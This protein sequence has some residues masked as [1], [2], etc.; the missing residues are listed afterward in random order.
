M[1]EA[2]YILYSIKYKNLLNIYSFIKN[3]KII[4]LKIKNKEIIF[5]DYKFIFYLYKYSINIL[6]KKKFFFN[7]IFNINNRNFNILKDFLLLENYSSFYYTFNNFYDKMIILLAYLYRKNKY[8]NN[9]FI[10]E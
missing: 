9:I 5:N 10:Q 1:L 4:Y 7:N 3:K 8:V 2:F 6:L